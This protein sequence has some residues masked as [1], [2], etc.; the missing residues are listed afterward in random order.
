[1]L[2]PVIE[3]HTLRHLKKGH[4][5]ESYYDGDYGALF[6]SGQVFLVD[7]YRKLITATIIISRTINTTTEI[8]VMASY[9]VVSLKITMFK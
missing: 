8:K 5:I 4:N 7:G 1:M 6:S 3:L 9:K 2:S